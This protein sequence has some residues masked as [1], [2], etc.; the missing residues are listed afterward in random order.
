MSSP[1]QKHVEVTSL[2]AVTQ[3]AVGCGIGLLMANRLQST[4]RKV[5]GW[6]MVSLGLASVTPL[7]VGY[8]ARTANHPGSARAMRRRLDSIRQDSGFSESADVF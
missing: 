3:A 7:V 2:V 5:T 8:F 4:P 6:I 1:R